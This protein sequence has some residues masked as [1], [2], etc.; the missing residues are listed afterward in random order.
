MGYGCAQ[1]GDEKEVQEA[2]DAQQ[3]ERDLDANLIAQAYEDAKAEKETS[4][5]PDDIDLTLE[6]LRT[7]LDLFFES[8]VQRGQLGARV[9]DPVSERQ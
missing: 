1:E 6:L 4:A 5:E 8:H 7:P 3:A 2:I 9:V